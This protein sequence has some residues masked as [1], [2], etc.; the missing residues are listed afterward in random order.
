MEI[1]DF[2]NL[3]NKLIDSYEKLKFANENLT[4]ACEYWERAYNLAKPIQYESSKL[5]DVATVSIVD[6]TKDAK[7]YVNPFNNPAG[8]PIN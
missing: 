3:S 2:I 8:V 6:L 7:P 5:E 4:K 1:D